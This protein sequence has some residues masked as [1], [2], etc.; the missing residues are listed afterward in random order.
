MDTDG[1]MHVQE[2]HYTD[3]QVSTYG[4]LYSEAYAAL[5]RANFEAGEPRKDEWLVGAA[6]LLCL[7]QALEHYAQAV[8]NESETED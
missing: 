3:Q 6:V 4:E 2:F 7:E 5:E 8:E 1:F